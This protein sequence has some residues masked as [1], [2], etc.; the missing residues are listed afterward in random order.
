MTVEGFRWVSLVALVV[1]AASAGCT[2]VRAT[3]GTVVTAWA[4]P[5][6]EGV[7][8][9]AAHDLGCPPTA[10]DVKNVSTDPN[11]HYPN[12]LVAEGCGWSA[13]YHVI[14]TPGRG[15]YEAVQVSRTPLTPIVQ[16]GAPASGSGC[17]KDTDCKTPPP[18]PTAP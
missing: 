2:T 8:A 10:I 13:N 9:S 11:V 5:S 18:A 4:V 6:V 17:S 14:S 7:R 1:E 3:D 16:P 15:A 12:D